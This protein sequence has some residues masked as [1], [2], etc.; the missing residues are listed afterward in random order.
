VR[1]WLLQGRERGENL[2][3]RSKFGMRA[4]RNKF[5]AL[6]PEALRG[7]SYRKVGKDGKG[8]RKSGADLLCLWQKISGRVALEEYRGRWID[9][10]VVAAVPSGVWFR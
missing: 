6:A 3:S 5:G 9:V 2:R 1:H 8:S 4:P 7:I 10:E